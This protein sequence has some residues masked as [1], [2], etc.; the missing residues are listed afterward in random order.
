M[1]APAK[2]P[3]SATKPASSQAALPKTAAAPAPSKSSAEEG[4]WES[5]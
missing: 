5:F 1:P 4:E 2:P 3:V